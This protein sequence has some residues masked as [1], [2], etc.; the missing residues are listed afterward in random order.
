MT[1]IPSMVFCRVIEARGIYVAKNRVGLHSASLSSLDASVGDCV[2]V[3]GGRRTVTMVGWVL[4]RPEEADSVSMDGVVRLN[5]DTRLGGR[6]SVFKAT[7]KPALSVV[8]TPKSYPGPKEDLEA[9]GIVNISSVSY[10]TLFDQPFTRYVKG[11]LAG[12]PLVVGD[13]VLVPVLGRQVPFSTVD[14]EPRGGVIIDEKTQ[15]IIRGETV[16]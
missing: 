16:K 8:L 3:E 2:S 5:C 10:P 15:L 14:T 4:S 1:S 13:I 11:K 6:V 12:Y 7:P 9:L